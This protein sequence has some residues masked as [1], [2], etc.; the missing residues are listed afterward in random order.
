MEPGSRHRSLRSRAPAL[1]IRIAGRA[2][3]R[4]PRCAL[5]LSIGHR[6]ECPVLDQMP[7]LGPGDLQRP[8]PAIVATV[9]MVGT[10]L[11]QRAPGTSPHMTG[12]RSLVSAQLRRRHSTR[13]LRRYRST[14]AMYLIARRSPRMGVRKPA[15]QHGDGARVCAW[16]D[17]VAAMASAN[18]KQAVKVCIGVSLS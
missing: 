10:C 8:R 17:A 9:H 3:P 13:T 18:V 12:L 1:A 15:N 14:I 7:W 11:V 6:P 5:T 16:T 2:T 4:S